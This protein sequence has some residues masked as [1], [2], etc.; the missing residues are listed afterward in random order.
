MRYILLII[1]L[2]SFLSCQKSID[3]FENQAESV[4]LTAYQIPGCAG[5]ASFFRNDISENDC[6]SYS[7]KDTLKIELCV[8][9][10]CCPDSHRFMYDSNI[11]NNV[12][13]FTVVDTAADLCRCICDYRIHADFAGL[14]NDEYIFNCIYGDTLLFSEVIVK[15]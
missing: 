15:K 5:P 13:S 8:S 14:M 12:I 4:D 6:F 11:D 7:F 10:N 3:P 2:L 9:A 1:F